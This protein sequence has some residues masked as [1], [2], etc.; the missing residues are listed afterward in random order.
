[1]SKKTFFS[2]EYDFHASPQLLYQY[3]STPLVC[4][5]GLPTTSIQEVK[6]SFYLG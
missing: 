5:N 3:L 2:V 4:Q 6:T 1:M